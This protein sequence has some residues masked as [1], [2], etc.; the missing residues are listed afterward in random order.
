MLDF[1]ALQFSFRGKRRSSAKRDTEMLS[2]HGTAMQRTLR[3]LHRAAI[4]CPLDL[5]S[6]SQ[7]FSNNFRDFVTELDR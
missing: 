6:W 7:P 5:G 4:G 3:E 2:I 1:G